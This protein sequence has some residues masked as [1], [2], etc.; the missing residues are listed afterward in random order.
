MAILN[1]YVSLSKYTSNIYFLIHRYFN[2]LEHFQDVYPFKDTKHSGKT[3]DFPTYPKSKRWNVLG[4]WWEFIGPII[5][6]HWVYFFRSDHF[7]PKLDGLTRSDTGFPHPIE[8]IAWFIINIPI[9]APWI[10][11]Q[12]KPNIKLVVSPKISPWNL[13][14]PPWNLIEMPH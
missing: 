3:Y 14:N 4:L 9:K 13:L 10:Y 1:S 8:I 7:P 6:I 11:F 5:A 2:I 12:T